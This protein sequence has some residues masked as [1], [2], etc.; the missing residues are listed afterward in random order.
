[1]LRQR[2]SS[3][4]IL[5][6]PVALVT[7]LGG[8]WFLVTLLIVIGLATYEFCDLMRRGGYRPSLPISLLTALALV[9]AARFPDPRLV[10]M[11]LTGA[12]LSALIWHLIDFEH[13][14]NT[15]GLDWGLTLGVGLYLG[16]MGGLLVRL[17]DLPRGLEWILLAFVPVWL[18]DTSA[19][20]VG[21][22]W[23]RHKCYPRLSPKK[24]WEGTVAGWVA[25]IATTALMGWL[26]GLELWQ[27]LGLGLLL[28]VLTPL[29]DVGES[30]FKRQVGA[31][32]SGNIIPGHG[33]VLDRIDSLL[34][35][36]PIVYYFFILVLVR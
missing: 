22:R 19:Y 10:E 3:V 28:A 36:V 9:V 27:G 29:G 21:V 8:W 12:L 16:W 18:A 32:D 24:S 17:R 30:M 20:F 34:F 6:P 33:G 7:Y 15:S 35:S 4:A 5:I 11:V 31:K 23:G 26:M 1:M 2:V 13:G 25:G 14:G